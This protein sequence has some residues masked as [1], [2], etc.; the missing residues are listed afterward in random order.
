[1]WSLSLLFFLSLHFGLHWVFIATHEFL[2]VV[3]SLVVEPGL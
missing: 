3:A 2:I 1:M